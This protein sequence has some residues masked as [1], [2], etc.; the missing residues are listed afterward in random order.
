MLT[1]RRRTVRRYRS[2]AV[3]HASGTRSTI[4]SR[5]VDPA[6]AVCR[7]L[8]VTDR[9]V[10]RGRPHS[11]KLSAVYVTARRLTLAGRSNR[12]V[13]DRRLKDGGTV[14]SC[15]KVCGGGCGSMTND[16][17]GSIQCLIVINKRLAIRVVTGYGMQA[18]CGLSRP[19]A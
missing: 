5:G 7:I 8:A 17:A 3:N 13:S 18:A 2:V 10:R 1:G 15:V 14:E 6:D 4:I 12:A 11:V 19:A 16:T 9:T